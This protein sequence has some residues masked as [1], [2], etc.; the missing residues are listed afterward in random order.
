MKKIQILTFWECPLYEISE[1]A[2][3]HDCVPYCKNL[4]RCYIWKNKIKFSSA[5]YYMYKFSFCPPNVLENSFPAPYM[6]SIPEYGKQQEEV[7]F[8]CQI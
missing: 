6:D 4:A 5:E 3:K 8:P 2:F 1:Y 7:L